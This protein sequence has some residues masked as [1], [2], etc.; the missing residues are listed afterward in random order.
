M[1]KYWKALLEDALSED[2]IPFIHDLLSLTCGSEK[3]V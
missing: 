2:Q 3:K 1:Q